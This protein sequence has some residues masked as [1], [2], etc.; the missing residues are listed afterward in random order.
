MK[1]HIHLVQV[2]YQVSWINLCKN[3]SNLLPSLFLSSFFWSRSNLGV[4]LEVPQK[5][6]P[7]LISEWKYE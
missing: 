7:Y 5:I 3:I 1:I 4:L 6:I 2:E